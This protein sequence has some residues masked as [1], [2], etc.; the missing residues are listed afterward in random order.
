MNIIPKKRPYVKLDDGLDQQALYV[1]SQEDFYYLRHD[2][3]KDIF[4]SPKKARNLICEGAS[5]ILMRYLAIAKFVG[6]FEVTTLYINGDLC[7]N[8][9]ECKGPSSGI[10]NDNKIDVCKIYRTI[11]E[12]C[13]IEHKS[14][15]LMTLSGQI[16]KQEWRFCN[17]ILQINPLV[18]LSNKEP[19][20]HERIPLEKSF[21]KDLQLLSLY[22][23]AK[24]INKKLIENYMEDHPEIKDMLA[25]YVQTVLQLKPEDV[26]EFTAKYFLAFTPALLPQS[27]YFEGPFDVDD[28]EDYEFWKYL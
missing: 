11:I 22:M 6:T 19:T 26:F 20:G 10:V 17:Y 21:G 28:D 25:D 1:N 3:K 2:K 16:L 5:F 9:Y 8:I 24:T 4:Y 27:E 23:D 12:E 18:D 15:T 13:G 7:R 14:I